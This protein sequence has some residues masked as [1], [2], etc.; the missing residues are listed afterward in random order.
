[1]FMP[2]DDALVQSCHFTGRTGQF[3]RFFTS[4]I[5]NEPMGILPAWASA[6]AAKEQLAED[7]RKTV[8]L[9]GWFDTERR[10]TP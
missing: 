3:F 4:M 7:P 2:D 5:G 6:E 1:M 8:P 10:Y 9:R